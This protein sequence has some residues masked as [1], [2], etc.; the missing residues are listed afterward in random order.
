MSYGVVLKEKEFCDGL[1]VN[2]VNEL[3]NLLDD[4]KAY[5]IEIYAKKHECSAMG[6]IS[7]K[8]AETIGYDYTTDGILNAR[9]EELHNFVA[10]ILDD[11]DNETDNHEYN[12][13]NGI[14]IYMSR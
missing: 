2:D 6:F 3:F 13:F 12:Y 11:M 10:N 14:K 8:G 5:P 9:G 7:V 1:T 4:S